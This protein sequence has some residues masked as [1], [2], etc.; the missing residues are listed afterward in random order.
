[1]YKRFERIGRKI[2]N[3]VSMARIQKIYN[4][5]NKDFSFSNVNLISLYRTLYI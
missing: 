3:N 1:M 5:G 2:I 4:Y